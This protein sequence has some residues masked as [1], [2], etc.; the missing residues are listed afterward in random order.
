MS[1]RMYTEQTIIP[2][3]NMAVKNRPVLLFF[4]FSF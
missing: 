4:N 1:E 2:A 3:W